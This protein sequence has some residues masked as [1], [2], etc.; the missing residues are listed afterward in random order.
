MLFNMSQY[1]RSLLVR[2]NMD[3]TLGTDDSD[4]TRSKRSEKCN[5]ELNHD[6]NG[7]RAVRIGAVAISMYAAFVFRASRWQQP[8]VNLD[9]KVSSVSSTQVVPLHRGYDKNDDANDQFDQLSIRQMK[10]TSPFCPRLFQKGAI[11]LLFQP[12]FVHVDRY[13][14]RKR[15]G[16]GRDGLTISSF[17]NAFPSSDPPPPFGPAFRFFER[18]LVARIQNIENLWHGENGGHANIEVVTDQH[19]PLGQWNLGNVVWPNNVYKAPD[20][21]FSFEALIVPQGFHGAFKAGRL[22]IINLSQRNA[23]GF[24]PEYV[25]HQS[26]TSATNPDKYYTKA[27]LLDMNGDGRKDMV[28]VRSSFRVGASFAPPSGELVWFEHPANYDGSQVWVEHKIYQMPYPGTGPD[29]DID[30]ADL[31]NDGVEEIITTHFFTGDV[32]NGQQTGGKVVLYGVPPSF[33]TW[34]NVGFSPGLVPPRVSTITANQGFP[35]C[36]KF[37]DLNNDGRLDILATNHQPEAMFSSTPGRVLAYEQPASGDLYNDPWPLHILKDDIRPNPNI[38]GTSGR[39]APGS[40]QTFYPRRH[41]KPWIIVDGKEASK[42]WVLK[43]KSSDQASWQYESAVI[44]D[45]N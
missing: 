10:E 15:R 42:V 34:T 43:P 44:F 28:T 2:G 41:Q 3:G 20:G 6:A 14:T 22:S 4:F 45:I 12:A 36:V 29:I 26:G 11:P 40:A 5:T 7:R 35:F 18:D 27:L 8:Q 19:L 13:K 25:I 38:P 21:V 24:Y 30:A 23:L 33:K 17:F 1:T 39:L 37:V 32:V 9:K 16:L 31:D